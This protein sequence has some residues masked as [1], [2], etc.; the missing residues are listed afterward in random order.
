MQIIYQTQFKQIGLL[1][2]EALQ[3][4]MF[5]TF[6]LGAP[7]DLVDYCFIHQHGELL[8]QVKVG[9]LLIIDGVS[10]VISAVGEIASFNLKELGHVTFCF[11]N[12][13]CA[14]YPG[15]IHLNGNIP[16]QLDVGST[17]IIKRN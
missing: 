14:R 3:E 2:R 12:A 17:L 8:D 1:A 13:S 16:K 7:A 6:K 5:I 15:T 11:D 10:F 9:D 4:N